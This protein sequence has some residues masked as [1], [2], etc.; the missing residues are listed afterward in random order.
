MMYNKMM[1]D[2]YVYYGSTFNKN[3]GK[4]TLRVGQAFYN[5]YQKKIFDNKPCPELFYCKDGDK[6]YELI[7]DIL[8]NYL[9][10]Q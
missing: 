3:T 2:F 10:N 1:T 7:G 9:K 6:T 8:T 5:F 4:P